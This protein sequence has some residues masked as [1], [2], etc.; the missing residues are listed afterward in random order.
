MGHSVLRPTLLGG[1]KSKVAGRR[2]E[3]VLGGQEG[4]WRVSEGG[5]VEG[6]VSGCSNFKNVPDYVWQLPNIAMSDEHW[7]QI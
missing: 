2:P 6:P 1:S 4:G 3:A 7:H 5:L